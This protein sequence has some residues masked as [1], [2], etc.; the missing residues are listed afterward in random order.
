MALN[1]TG[2]EL[3]EEVIIEAKRYWKQWPTD[4]IC[5]III[6]FTINIWEK[7]KKGRQKL[8][9]HTVYSH[10]ILDLCTERE[11][12]IEQRIKEL[13]NKLEKLS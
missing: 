9:M 4:T 2:A 6:P 5:E 11:K 13:E 7:K 1:I 3:L 10:V 12:S 8:A